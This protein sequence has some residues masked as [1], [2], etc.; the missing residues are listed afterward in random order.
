[1]FY[2]CYLYLFMHIG[3]Q[4]NFHISLFWCCFNS[5]T[6][7]AGT[8]TLSECLDSLTVLVGVALLNLLFSV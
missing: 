1:M 7:G 5:N 4:H 2:S 3:V 6:N 8:A